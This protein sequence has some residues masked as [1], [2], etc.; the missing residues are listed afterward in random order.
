MT[1]D[2]VY[3]SIADNIIANVAEGWS[4]A[5]ITAERGGDNAL[6]LEGGYDNGEGV[7]TPFKFRN[8]DRRV[9]ADFHQ[10][11]KITTKGDSN[12]WNRA[13]YILHPDGKF[14]IN[15]QWDQKLADDAEG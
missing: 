8:F 5:H 14:S 7:F 1:I 6:S 2:D 11:H 4:K 9:I 10:L 12:R 3:K 13:S 15:F